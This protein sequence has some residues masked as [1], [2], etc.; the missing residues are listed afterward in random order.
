[1]INDKKIF[2]IIFYVIIIKNKKKISI[3]SLI[4]NLIINLKNR[5]R[6]LLFCRILLIILFI[7]LMILFF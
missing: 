7:K 3:I 1:M 4:I 6:M 5:I 2:N